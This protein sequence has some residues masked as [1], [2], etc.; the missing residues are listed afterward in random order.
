MSDINMNMMGASIISVHRTASKGTLKFRGNLT[1]SVS[2][3]MGWGDLTQGQ[4]GAPMEGSITDA[5]L[6][7]APDQADLF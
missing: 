7:L 2:N 4:K 5:V 1:K 6:I 3:A